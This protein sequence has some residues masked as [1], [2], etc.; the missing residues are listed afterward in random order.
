L[1][2]NKGQETVGLAVRLYLDVVL[3]CS[4]SATVYNLFIYLDNFVFM[5]FHH[6]TDLHDAAEDPAVRLV[7][8]EEWVW[9]NNILLLIFYV[10]FP[11]FFYMPY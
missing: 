5:K 3:V 10:A 11:L 9:T 2:T 6:P 4:Q 8:Y 7:N 1:I